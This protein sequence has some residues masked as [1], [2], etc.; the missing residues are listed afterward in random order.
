MKKEQLEV[1]KIINT[2]GVRGEMKIQ[3]WLNDPADFRAIST[4]Y[5]NGTPYRVVS[6]R[7]QGAN[8]LVCLEG[9]HS[10]D[11]VLPLKN[12][13]AT[14]RREELPIQ[15]GEHFFADLIGMDAVN[16]ETDAVFGTV[17][18]IL[19]YPA[20]DIYQIAGADGK[21]YLIPDVPDFVVG[22]DDD[23]NAVLIRLVEGF[24]Q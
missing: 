22:I 6:A 15:D 7:T 23:R 4:L 8:A 10:I 16:V 3:S 20:Q 19:E 14:A 2:H 5:V 12:K 18:D 17:T 9:I 21:E 1:G 24:R 11:D 13:I